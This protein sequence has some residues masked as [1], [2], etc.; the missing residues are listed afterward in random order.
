M[1][2]EDYSR[3]EEM[4]LYRPTNYRHGGERIIDVGILCCCCHRLSA[5][6]LTTIVVNGKKV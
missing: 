2:S 6:Y 3:N 5:G 4:T 1:V